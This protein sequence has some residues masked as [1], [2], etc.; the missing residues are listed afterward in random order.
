MRLKNRKRKNNDTEK[1]QRDKENTKMENRKDA[2]YTDM[3]KKAAEKTEETKETEKA[4]EQEEKNMSQ[5]KRVNLDNGEMTRRELREHCFKMLFCQDFYPAEEK[6]EQLER[7][8]E[9]PKEDVT[10]EDGKDE[11]LHD[12]FEKEEDRAYLEKRVEKIMELIPEIDEKINE[13]AEGWRTRRMGKVELTILRLAVFEMKY[14]EEI[15]EKVA[16][17]EAVELA[18]KFGGDEAPAFVNGILAKLIQKGN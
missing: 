5:N 7:Y 15:P 13:I 12:P 1:R 2:M 14:D 8:F 6:E 9:A 17:N 3:A 16:I 10:G 11:I 4:R 18:K